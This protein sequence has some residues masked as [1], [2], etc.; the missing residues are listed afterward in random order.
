MSHETSTGTSREA[1]QALDGGAD[2]DGGSDVRRYVKK[3][4]AVAALRPN[5]RWRFI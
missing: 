5:C 1:Q 3:E 2:A 4:T